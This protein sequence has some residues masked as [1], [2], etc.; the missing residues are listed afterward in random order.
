MRMVARVSMLA[1]GLLL[2]AAAA[3]AP[4]AEEKAP[5]GG[6]SQCELRIEGEH[7]AWLR[8]LQELRPDATRP[9]GVGTSYSYERPE[10]ILH[11]PQG[12]YFVEELKL[13]GGYDLA[14]GRRSGDEFFELTPGRPTVL[15]VGAPL[16]PTVKVTR[17]G[18]YLALDYELLDAGGRS[19]RKASDASSPGRPPAPHFAVYVGEKKIGGGQFAYG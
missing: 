2:A 9:A 10:K 6:K 16:S 5:A 1:C 17:Q 3:T 11:L 7:I 15:T 19:Y 14:R 12:R 4:S 18:P 8:L 13:D